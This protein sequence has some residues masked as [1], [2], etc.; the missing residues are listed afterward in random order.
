MKRVIFFDPLE[1]RQLAAESSN[2]RAPVPAA[3]GNSS[4]SRVS[5]SSGREGDVQQL[6][7]DLAVFA[8]THRPRPHS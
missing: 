2:D 8:A 7:H 6:I 3:P 4:A 1:V 5:P